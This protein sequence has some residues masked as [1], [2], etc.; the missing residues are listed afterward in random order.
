MAS[1]AGNKKAP[2][3]P[4]L[5]IPDSR[6]P[7]SSHATSVPKLDSVQIIDTQILLDKDLRPFAVR[8]MG[9]FPPQLDFVVVTAK[10]PNS[11]ILV[12]TNNLICFD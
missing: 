5:P 7:E 12:M 8:E 3:V 1:R 11:S 9:S 10:S 6:Q 4:K 2:G